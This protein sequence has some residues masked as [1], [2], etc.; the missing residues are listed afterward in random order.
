MSFGRQLRY[1]RKS[2]KIGLRALAKK[3]KYDRAY[4]SRVENSAV[5]PSD[6]LI[7]ATA[8]F[9]KTSENALRIA[10]GKFPPDILKILSHHPEESVSLL[11]DSL[12]GNS[13]MTGLYCCGRPVE[14]SNDKIDRNCAITFQ[15]TCGWCK[16]SFDMAVKPR[17]GSQGWW[18]FRAITLSQFEHAV[19]A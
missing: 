17:P 2:R 7:K 19:K 14:I 1:L 5:N 12:G 10:A 18:L 11:R 15:A 8:R 16:T 3:L 4:L 9:F 6:D 13:S